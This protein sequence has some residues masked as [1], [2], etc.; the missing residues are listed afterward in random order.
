MVRS[1]PSICAA[2]SAPTA[3][4]FAVRITTP[5]T[6]RS[7]LPAR[8]VQVMSDTSSSPLPAFPSAVRISPV[9]ST[10]ASPVALSWAA[11]TTSVPPVKS[12]VQFR[13]EPR[14]S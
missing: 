14:T 1:A 6:S 8:S 7:P 10:L 11:I 13:S 3:P 5:D 4:K 2:R 12:M 9:R